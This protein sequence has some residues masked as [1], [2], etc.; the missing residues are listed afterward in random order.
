MTFKRKPAKKVYP[1]KTTINLAMRDMPSIKFGVA[2]PLILLILALAAAFSKF[3]VIDRFEKVR[4]AEA[5]VAALQSQKTA[6]EKYTANYTDVQ[7]EYVRYSTKWMTDAESGTVPR[8][9]MLSL[10]EKELAGQYRVLDF[11]ANGNVV[12]LKIAGGTLQE[13][14][15]IVTKLYAR[16]DVSS[17]EIFNASNKETYEI[18]NDNGKTQRVV[19]EVISIVITMN[20]VEQEGGAK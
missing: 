10:V 9:D 5:A 6:L 3:A 12:S 16:E 11:S 15:R 17:V 7:N 8:M 4:E 20:K 1:S 19:D 18:T 13:I 2:F 14:S